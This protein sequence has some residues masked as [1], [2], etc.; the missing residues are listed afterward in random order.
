MQGLAVFLFLVVIAFLV[1]AAFVIY[2][3]FKILEFVIRA[4]KLYERMVSRL[5]L[6]VKLLADI[7]GVPPVPKLAD[8]AL[9]DVVPAE[10]ALG[11]IRCTSCG[12]MSDRSSRFCE[13]CGRN[14][15]AD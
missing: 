7:R 13:Q 6:M 5:D 4:V 14:L 2:F 8:E 12:A 10:S 3:I 11:R 15:L 9:H 1:F